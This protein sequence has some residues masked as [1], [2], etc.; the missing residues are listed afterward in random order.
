MGAPQMSQPEDMQ[1]R[2]S[3]NFDKLSLE[4]LVKRKAELLGKYDASGQPTN[5]TMITMLDQKIAAKQPG[6]GITSG[7][8]NT[9]TTPP[10]LT[11]QPL[12]P[13]TSGSPT[14][15]AGTTPPPTTTPS[16]SIT[17]ALPSAP[18]TATSPQGGITGTGDE[19][20]LL[21]EAELQ[22]QLASQTL[23]SQYSARQKY[24]TDLSGLLQTQQNQQ[25]SSELPGVYEDL[26]TRGLLRSSDLGNRL[27]L[28]QKELAAITSSA[29]AQQ[30]LGYSDE[31]TS[32]LGN[33]ENAYLGA[34]SG[35]IQRAFSVDDYR[36]SIEA[37][38][39]LGFALQPQQQQSSPGKGGALSGAATGAFAGSKLG[40]WGGAIGAG[41]G[42][43]AGAGK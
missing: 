9:T 22:K 1:Q 15:P 37:S 2:I 23:Q 11:I 20:R 10:V 38:K 24:L 33:I 28:R 25:L 35:A 6:G 42:G 7:M 18:V 13:V 43:V 26:N 8:T 30:G 40:P 4:E 19:T 36:R 32:G 14:P 3:D 21:A 27:S 31:Y 16:G 5:S 29:L 39:Q 41:V 34:R 17:D 12:L